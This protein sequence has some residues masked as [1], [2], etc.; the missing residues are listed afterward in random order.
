MTPD[1][2]LEDEFYEKVVTRQ[3]P[4]LNYKFKDSA[5]PDPGCGE[6]DAS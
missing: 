6:T 2:L 4:G 3:L 5:A 1:L